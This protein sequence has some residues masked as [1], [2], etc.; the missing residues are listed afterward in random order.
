MPMLTGTLITAAGF[1]PIGLAQV[2]DRRVHLRDLRGHGGG[3]ADLVVGVGVLRALPRHPAAAS[4]PHA[5]RCGRGRTSCSTRRS[6]SR[7]R[8][9]VN[10]CVQHRWI[11]IGCHRA[12]LRA[13]H[14]RHGPGAAAVLPR[15]EPARDPG[16]P[17]VARRHVVSQRTKRSPSASSAHDEGAAASSTV[18]HLGRLAACRASTCRSTRSSRRPTSARCI[19]LPKDLEAR[20]AL[21]KRLPALLAERVPRGA[22][23]RQAAAQRA[24]GAVPGAVPRRRARRRRRCACCADEVKAIMRTNP[25]MRGVN[26]NWNESVKVLR[27]EVDQDKARAL[28]VTSQSIAQAS[29]TILSRHHDRPVPRGR[30]AD[31]HRAAPAAGRAQRDH[32]PRQRLPAHQPAA[33]VDSADAD[34]QASASPG[35]RA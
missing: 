30:Q 19:V 27:L 10:W 2:G 29:R 20:E 3:A 24:A 17:V 9:L 33:A 34:R 13:R 23:P 12:D 5:R 26:D 22:R 4:T 28:G 1:L 15:F 32:R 31:R 18:T 16:R 14:R 25:N 35:S 8:A 7:F 6:T 11:T 21:R